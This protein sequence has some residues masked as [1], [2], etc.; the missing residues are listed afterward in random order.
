[1]YVPDHFREDRIP[2]LQETMRQIGFGA[3]VTLGADGIVAS[4]IPMLI[5]AEPS[6]WGRLSGHLARSNPQ[7]QS[8]RADIEAL[9]IFSGPQGYITPSWY[10]TKQATG[11]VVPTWNYLA[12]HAYGRLR[13]IDD[14]D[15]TRAH[16][17]RLT[18]MHEGKRAVP[19]RVSDAPAAYIEAMIKGIIGFEL[20]LTRIEGKWKMSQNRPAEDRAGVVAG[21]S[22]EGADALAA[23]I[24]ER[25]AR[26]GNS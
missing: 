13:F 20:L 11:K 9:A 10:P 5:E 18:A 21:L 22:E 26:D 19:W 24:A 12:I 17:T 25:A 4:H 2:V 8:A 15:H 23:L 16:I 1:M 6:P 3:L 14:L 7:W